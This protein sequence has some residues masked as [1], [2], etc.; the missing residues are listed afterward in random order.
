M[1]CFV[2]FCADDETRVAS[3][4]N[5][6]QVAVD[7]CSSG[8]VIEFGIGFYEF[9]GECDFFCL[10]AFVL[11]NLSFDGINLYFMSGIVLFYMRNG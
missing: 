10:P 3:L 6:F 4:L 9:L 1:L 11:L 7:I 5:Q 2:E 8:V